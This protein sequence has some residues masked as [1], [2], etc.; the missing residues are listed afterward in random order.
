MSVQLAAEKFEEG[1]RALQEAQQVEAEHQARLRSIHAQ[2]ERLR[3]QEQHM[4]QVRGI[5]SSVSTSSLKMWGALPHPVSLWSSYIQQHRR[6]HAHFKV[7]LC[8]VKI[9]F[10]FL[11]FNMSKSC[12]YG[13]IWTFHTNPKLQCYSSS[14]LS[15]LHTSL[16]HQCI[17]TLAIDHIHESWLFDVIFQERMRMTERMRMREVENTRHSLP[18]NLA[19]APIYTGTPPS[20]LN[21]NTDEL[22]HL[23]VLCHIFSVFDDQFWFDV[24][25]RYGT[26]GQ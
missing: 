11:N 1:E 17:F 25:C 24:D 19:T 16:H 13:S 3:Q 6:Q 15:L 26:S 8:H 9:L 12:M 5:R 4:H 14:L 20:L 10:W 2:M 18:I 7:E 22:S 21:T 23:N